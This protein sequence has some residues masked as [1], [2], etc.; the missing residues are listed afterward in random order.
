VRLGVEVCVFVFVGVL[1]KVGVKVSDGVKL[2]VGVAVAVSVFVIV[3]STVVGST[4]LLGTPVAVVIDVDSGVGVSISCN[5][6]F[7]GLLNNGID[8]TKIITQSAKVSRGRLKV[9]YSTILRDN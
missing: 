7:D 5:L 6:M 1:V 2:A 9:I 8:V 4:V 3:G